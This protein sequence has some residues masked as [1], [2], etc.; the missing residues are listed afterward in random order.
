VL[1]ATAIALQTFAAAGQEA[2]AD[3]AGADDTGD[4]EPPAAQQ[5]EI[6]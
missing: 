2:P 1:T 3:P 6:A 5:I 4:G